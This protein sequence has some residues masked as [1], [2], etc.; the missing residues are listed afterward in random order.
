MKKVE[1]IKDFCRNILSY[2]GAGYSDYK[3]NVIPEK[4][5]A[6]ALK[7]S[8]IQ[9]KIIEKYDTDL[10]KDQRYYKKSKGYANY[11][12]IYFKNKIYLF[13]TSGERVETENFQEVPDQLTLEI[14]EYLTLILFRDER[15]KFTFKMSKG[16]F[17]KIK[18]KI[19]IALIKK[20]GRS[21]H[22]EINKLR[23]LPTYRGIELQKNQ[24]KKWIKKEQKKYKTNFNVGSMSMWKPKRV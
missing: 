21:F 23:G 13:R 6:D 16:T 3:I 1:N 8:R 17:R 15:G 10:T 18:E 7:V 4:K 24:L 9:K 2:V 14:S 20:D 22:F 5:A 19:R 11:G 12:S